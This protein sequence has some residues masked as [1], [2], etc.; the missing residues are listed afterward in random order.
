MTSFTALQQT[1]VPAQTVPQQMIDAAICAYSVTDGK[2]GAKLNA[3][4][5]FYEPIGF[6]NPPVAF[7]AGLDDI[8]A[9]FLGIDSQGWAILSLRGTLSRW[10]SVGGDVQSVI[11]WLNDLRSS[12]VPLYDANGNF[13]GNVEDGWR[14]A[15]STIWQPI[16]T[17]LH[18]CD[19]ANLNGLRI[20]GHSKGAGLTF[21]AAALANAE[22]SSWSGGGPKAIE[23]HAFAAPLAGDASFAQQY[24]NARLDAVTTRYQRA[25]DIVPFVPRYTYNGWSLFDELPDSLFGWALWAIKDT[26][27]DGYELLGH[28]KYYA[29]KGSSST[30]PDPVTGQSAHNKAQA[31][32]IAAIATD[33]VDEIKAAHSSVYS[34][35]P[36]IFKQ[37][38][39]TQSLSR[40]EI[41]AKL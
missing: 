22:K 7:A 1:P 33:A 11:D 3:P 5:F 6:A 24:S 36:A 14:S 16:R 26:V 25:H 2:S 41:E 13:L 37:A 18:F 38:Y 23:V 12:L 17:A 19:W 15:L 39:P 10:G 20:T 29:D 32:I 31:A 4:N 8:N 27:E 35:W 40:E 9:A 21:L 34:Y 30:W 28:L